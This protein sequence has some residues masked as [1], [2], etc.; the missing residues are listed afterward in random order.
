MSRP[1][2]EI[3]AATVTIH[4]PGFKA[5]MALATGLS[6]E[7]PKA[8][9]GGVSAATPPDD[10]SAAVTMHLPGFKE[11]MTFAT[12]LSREGPTAASSTAKQSEMSIR[13]AFEHAARER[14]ALSYPAPE[15][16][17]P[18]NRAA[19]EMV[20]LPG[21]K[22]PVELATGQAP[23]VTDRIAAP[24]GSAN[25]FPNYK[26]A[27]EIKFAAAVAPAPSAPTKTAT[28]APAPHRPISRGA[29]FVVDGLAEA[30][31]DLKTGKIDADAYKRRVVTL[32]NMG[33][34]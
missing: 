27:A 31:D 24:T 1:E 10:T 29:A 7:V 16:T 21:F 6:R 4:L 25:P 32:S 30:A 2:E 19:T 33:G 14:G 28:P 11:P 20:L 23:V 17:G 12:G 18:S 34:Y 9:L 13:E 22:G 5:P 8:A 3:A 15:T 26:S